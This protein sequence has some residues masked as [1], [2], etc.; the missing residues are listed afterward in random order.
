MNRALPLLLLTASCLGPD[1]TEI[2]VETT[3]TLSTI[4]DLELDDNATAQLTATCERTAGYAHASGC[5]EEQYQAWRCMA[6]AIA[7]KSCAQAREAVDAQCS[8]A[9]GR[10]E[11]CLPTEAED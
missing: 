3:H 4:C 5:A 10:V 1:I 7:G 6:H 9:Y 11:G 8:Y 2:C